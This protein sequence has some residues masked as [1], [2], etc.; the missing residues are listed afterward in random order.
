MG[1]FD[2]LKKPKSNVELLDDQIWLTKQ[3]K[4]AG[5][6]TATGRCLAGPGRPL[7]VLWVAHFRDCLEE[8]QATVSQGGVDR[9]SVITITAEQLIEQSPSVIAPGS[10]QSVEILVAERHPLPE[11]DT[12][13]AEFAQTLPCRCRLI[14][15][16]SLEDAVMQAFAGEWVH[17]VL[18]QLGMK[19]TESIESRM[20]G[21]RIQQALQK[22]AQQAVSD[23]RADS[24]EE[25]LRR[26]CPAIRH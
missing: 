5:I 16:V 8:L 4:F 19:E 13:I 11:H 17:N 26:N 25:W 10:T 15:H 24:A 1:I 12:A 3:A 6:S 14:H 7:A 20:V 18:R 9:Q 22:T 2:W 21:R 23:L